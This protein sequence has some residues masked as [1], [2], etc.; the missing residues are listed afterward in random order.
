MWWE[1]YRDLEAQG[2]KPATVRYAHV[3]LG[4]CLK[5]AERTGVIARNPVRNATPPKASTASGG[6]ALSKADLGRLLT[7]FKG[8]PVFPVIALAAGTGARINEVLALEWAAVNWLDKTLRIDAALKPTSDGLQRGTPKT[9]RSRRTI[10]LDEGLLAMLQ[11]QRERQEA[12]QRALGGLGD[13]V[14]ALRSL[15]P[16]RALIF[17]ASP[18]DPPAPAPRPDQQGICGNGREVRLS[19][20]VP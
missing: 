14:V 19:C 20:S 11:G 6:N 12:E 13:D 3:V 2:L 7:A 10:R 17:P 16:E 8:D 1:F 5:H 18:L 4:S 9:Q 15:L